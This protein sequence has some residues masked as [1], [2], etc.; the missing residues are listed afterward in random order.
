[1]YLEE[2]SACPNKDCGGKLEFAEPENC[3]CHINP[4]CSSCVNAPFVCD[5]CGD[6]F[7]DDKNAN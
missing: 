4:P 3:S 6:E 2:G 7:E 5:T 1:M